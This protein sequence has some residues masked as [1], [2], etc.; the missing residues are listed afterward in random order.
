M[1]RVAAPERLRS[2]RGAGIEAATE[3]QLWQHLRH[4]KML[5]CNSE[6]FIPG[7]REE[8]E[9]ETFKPQARTADPGV[10]ARRLRNNPGPPPTCLATDAVNSEMQ[11]DSAWSARLQAARPK[12]WRSH[13]LAFSLFPHA[14]AMLIRAA[15]T[16]RG[17]RRIR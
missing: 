3:N 7:D 9:F 14:G 15:A 13:R 8:S 1:Q 16:N 17:S 10:L 4:C 12:G 6:E 11:V 5:G 2:R